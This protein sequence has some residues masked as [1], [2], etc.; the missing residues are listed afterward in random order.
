MSALH[1]SRILLGVTG[2]IAAYKCP[3]LI[4]RLQDQGA[5]VTVVMTEAA[6]QFVTPLT[7]QT[8]SRR[9][10]YSRQFDPRDEI[11]HLTLVQE[12]DLFLIA[13]ATANFIGKAASGL[14][15][16][17]LSTLFLAARG[18]VLLAPAMD[19]AMWD[20]PV[21]RG[22]LRQLCDVGIDVI[23]PE[24]GSLASGL[25]G[26][27]R[28][29]GIE[30]IIAAAAECLASRTVLAGEHVL[31]TAGPT[32]EPLDPVRFL[33]NRSSGKMGYAI[34]RSAARRGARVTL[35]SGPTALPPP[36]GVEMVAV[37]TAAEMAAALHKRF[38]EATLLVMAAAVADYRPTQTD[39]K[40]IKRQPTGL[41]IDLES[42][43]DLLGQLRPERPRQLLVGFAAETEELLPR[44]R[45]KLE[46]KQL[47]LIAANLVGPSLGFDR[48]EI[49]LTLLDRDGRVID[50]G[51]LPKLV[52]AGRLLDTA[53][54]L[55]QKA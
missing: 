21:T 33:S 13:P 41:R 18:P 35:I 48:D 11:L 20:H 54:A 47:D 12:A 29:A 22:Q 24:A 52:A 53:V 4:R 14:A 15:D 38:S 26:M 23:G 2:S 50:L 17:L 39:S 19:A 45:R 40:K 25:V 43:P 9:P 51:L 6:G 5:T 27:G 16:D 55:R 31:V 3:E 44:A 36:F 42:V 46:D 32:R 28:L 37:E 10:V 1:G 49:A 34:A 7:L 30:T 8:I